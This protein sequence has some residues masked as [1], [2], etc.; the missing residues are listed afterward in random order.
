[1][2]ATSVLVTNAMLVDMAQATVKGRA[3][4]AGTGDPQDLSKAQLLTILNVEDGADVTDTANVTAAGALMDSEV[5]ADLKTLNLPANTTISAFGATL[6]D[7]VDAATARATLDVDQAGTDNSTDVTLAGTPDYLTIVGQVIT[8]GLIDLAADVTGNL[9]VGNLNS[10]TGASG[11][12]FWRGDGTWAT[13]AGSGDVSKVGTPVDNQLGVWTGDGTIEGDIDLTFDTATNVLNV[14]GNITLSGTVDGRDVATDGTKLDGI[15]TAADVTDTAN[16]TAAGALMDSEVDADIK[17][18]VLPAS[19]TISAFGATLVDDATAAAA[20]TTLDVDQAGTDNS[21][22]VTLAGT[23]DYLTLVG[24]VLTRGLI[25][26]GTDTTGTLSVANITG[27][28]AQFDTAVSDGNIA[29]DGGAHHDGFS[30]FVAAE[31]VDWAGASAGTVHQTNLPANL[32]TLT[33]PVSTTISAFGATLV[34]DASAGAALTTLGVTAFAQT[35]LDDATAGDA[36]TTLGVDPIGTDN[37]TDVTIAVGRDYVTI[38]GQELTLGP[39]DLS[40]AA[41]ITGN[42]PVTNL[43]SGTSASGATFWRGDGVWAAPA[44]SG[45]VSAA[46]VLADNTIV[47]GDGGAKGVQDS[48]ITISDSDEVAVPT[49]GSLAVGGSEDTIVVQGV[50]LNYDMVCHNEGG[51]TEIMLGSSR[52]TATAGAGATLALARSKGT[53]ASPTAVANA[54]VIGTIE[55]FAHDGTDYNEG[56]VIRATVDGTPGTNDLPCKLSFYT[57]PDGLS[58]SQERLRIDPDGT[59]NALAGL[60]VTGNIVVSGTVDGRDVDADGTSQ[61]S[62]I[63]DSAIHVDW[64]GASAG[65]VHQTNLPANLNTLTVPVSTTISAFG[66]TLVD[67]ASGSAAQTTLGITAFAQTILDDVDAATA[68]GTLG[69]DAA[70]TDNSTDVT[71][72]V[73]L[74]YV[75]ISGQE[76]TLGSVDLAADVT[77]NLPVTNLNSGTGASGSTFWRGDGTWAA[78]G[79]AAL[80]VVDTTSIVEDPGDPTK[81]MRIDVGA[82]LTGTVRVLSMADQNINL[83]PATGTYAA[84]SHGHTGVGDGGQLGTAGL[85]DDAVTYAKMQNVVADDRLLGNVAGAG[86]IVAELDATTVLTLLGVEAGATADQ[87]AGEIESIV[88]HDNLLNF[89]AN[90]HIDWTGA[91]AGTIHTTNFAA[92]QNVVEDTTPQLG[93]DL[94]ANGQDIWFDD[95]DGI[96]DKDGDEILIFKEIAGAPVNYLEIIN[97]ITAVGPTISAQ[98]E[99]NVNLHLAAKGTG[100]IFPGS[101]VHM[102]ELPVIFSIKAN[103]ITTGASTIDWTAGNKQVIDLDDD[104]TLTFTTPGAAANLVLKVIQGSGPYAITWPGTV[105]WAHGAVPSVSSGD[106]DVDIFTFFFDGTTYYGAVLNDFA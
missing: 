91:S 43:N 84:A 14:G 21:T 15:E 9:P 1:M 90:E 63:A 23:P 39:V 8:R 51:L 44:G 32:N 73:G 30:D 5:D 88:S 47:R 62:H 79:G 68:R 92:L 95:G 86:G 45:D 77:G 54:D 53:K 16:V 18:L 52:N 80:P 49:G 24:Q 34:D 70:G 94:D 98:G 55:F 12:T 48:G 60:G 106:N 81:E 99:T 13:P 71:I 61:D 4:G 104:V 46:A 75:T 69:V 28:K 36:R 19:T 7:D 22:D 3:S 74:D 29:Y 57:T 100:R 11:S 20:R 83:T 59:V 76:L 72:A 56:A 89:V 82:V 41:D 42:L 67:D 33:V 102:I 64:A 17:T 101:R 58:A 65:T 93:G 66:A 35:L 10:G 105:K 31:H 37:S 6:V 78:A 87:T 96:R 85:L 40:L 103:T 27:T 38:S 25:D 2:R 26:L 97:S 50:T